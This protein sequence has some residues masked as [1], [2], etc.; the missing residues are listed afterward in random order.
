MWGS[1]MR[2]GG[3]QYPVKQ[4]PCARLCV[5]SFVLFVSILALSRSERVSTC[6]GCLPFVFRCW[7]FLAVF[8]RRLN[9]WSKTHL[10]ISKINRFVL[11]VLCHPS[12]LCKTR[13][14]FSIKQQGP[15]PIS[16]NGETRTYLKLWWFQTAKQRQ[17]SENRSIWVCVNFR[18]FRDCTPDVP[19]QGLVNA[20]KYECTS[21]SGAR[22]ILLQGYTLFHLHCYAPTSLAL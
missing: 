9:T 21:T 3:E 22:S 18:K 6:L 10:S 4:A 15:P 5:V 14:F 11:R 2:E 16:V 17:K 7:V 19:L 12:R 13:F 20:P 8:S 1:Q